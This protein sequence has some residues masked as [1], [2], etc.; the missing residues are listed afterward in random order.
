[1]MM[2]YNQGYHFIWRAFCY[3]NFSFIMISNTDMYRSIAIIVY[4][5]NESRKAYYNFL[6]E[7]YKVIIYYMSLFFF[8]CALIYVRHFF[9]GNLVS[10]RKSNFPTCSFYLSKR[11]YCWLYWLLQISPMSFSF[12]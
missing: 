2:M 1:M 12:P 4:L 5:T 10:V 7:V 3:I 9:L 6:N 8:L 11:L